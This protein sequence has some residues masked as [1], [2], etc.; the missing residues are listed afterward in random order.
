MRAQDASQL[1]LLES[2]AAAHG[3]AVQRID[4]DTLGRME[5][6]VRSATGEALLVPNT[7]VVSPSA[8][9]D[10][11]SR[12]CQDASVDI[13]CGGRLERVEPTCQRLTW[14]GVGLSYGH[15]INC[16][17][18]HADTVAHHFG[19]GRR[20][21]LLPFRGAYWRLDPHS[22]IRLRHLIYPVPD[23]RVP[24]L[25]VHTTTSV[26]G[27]VYLGP[28][29]TPAFGRE[30]YRGLQGIT[31]TEAGRI[32]ALLASQLI[33]GR[34]GFRR[35]AWQESARIS[36]RGFGV[37]ARALLPGLRIEHLLATDKVG[38]RAQLLD[39]TTG[40][41]VMDFLVERGHSATHV[42]NAISPAFT[43][44]FALARHLIDGYIEQRSL[45]EMV[46][47]ER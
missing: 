14:A 17:G 46:E 37:A 43:S 10:A 26:T 34:D 3:I 19:A 9:L 39:R 40:R 4:R 33:V 29:A 23:L 44:A 27:D 21:T 35:L 13:R 20:Y 1:G 7:A 42:L 47:L 2:R 5:P 16:A 30:N 36:K 24:F 11:V 32:A 18:A 6:D 31:L 15:A 28:T 8:V 38:I 45:N 12:E 41:L 25:G 22:G